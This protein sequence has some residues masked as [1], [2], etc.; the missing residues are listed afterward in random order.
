VEKDEEGVQSAQT[1]GHKIAWL[2]K[3]L[4]G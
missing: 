1:L 4:N 3:K 2:V